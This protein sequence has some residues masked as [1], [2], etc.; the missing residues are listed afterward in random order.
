MM[1]RDKPTVVVAPGARGVICGEYL[2]ATDGRETGGILLGHV[3]DGVAT[4]LHAGAPGPAAV[5]RR[6]YFLR[7]RRHAQRLADTA[8]A[9]D[10]SVWIGEWHSHV[11]GPPVPS[12]RD[13]NTYAQLVADEEIASDIVISLIIGKV[14]TSI[15]LTAWGC[16]PGEALELPLV[17]ADPHCDLGEHS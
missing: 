13:L 8:F 15:V 17:L 14:D 2:A 3:T 11:A 4:I 7:D 10:G 16:V 1:P 12:Q 9:T 6:D 5:R